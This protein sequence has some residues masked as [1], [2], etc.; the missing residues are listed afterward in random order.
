MIFH[1]FTTFSS[2][3]MKIRVCMIVEYQENN[4]LTTYSQLIKYFHNRSL[5]AF[6]SVLLPT[7][8]YLGLIHFL[9]FVQMTT[10]KLYEANKV[11]FQEM[12]YF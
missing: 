1:L 3:D 4:N 7:Q 5:A 10:F 12:Y 8:T 11:H 2:L 9:S 6:Q